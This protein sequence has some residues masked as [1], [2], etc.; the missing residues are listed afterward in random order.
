MQADIP[1]IW[2][3]VPTL[4]NSGAEQKYRAWLALSLHANMP[5]LTKSADLKFAPERFL[6]GV[7]AIIMCALP[8]PVAA[9]PPAPPGV[10]SGLVAL[11][12]R[13]RDYHRAVGALLRRI[14]RTLRARYP[15]AIFRPFCDTLP[16]SERTYAMQAG[17][18]R[19]AR[20]GLLANGLYGT[21]FV[22]GGLL[23]TLPFAEAAGDAHSLLDSKPPHICAH[24]RV[25]ADACPGRSLSTAP[26]GSCMLDVSRCLAWLSIENKDVI[27]IQN[28][29]LFGERIF[30]CDICQ[31]VCPY[32]APQLGGSG[33][34]HHA[35]FDSDH[36]PGAYLPLAE[37]LA[38][39]DDT[40]FA[41]RF[42][43]TALMRAKRR[44]LVRNAIIVTANG[45]HT[46]LMSLISDLQ[47][48]PDPVIAETAR[49]AASLLRQ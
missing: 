6:P 37:I 19:P 13:G 5:C 4:P 39:R 25:C 7:Q 44:G 35:L 28:W 46:S 30:G 12:A 43:G 38:I 36:A 42:S 22:L 27:P 31:D 17:L 26:D 48:D 33:G 9:H 1:A 24:C 20:S 8:L 15:E 23:T 16:L 34:I 45:R 41:Q 14:I 40:A 49:L 21:H 47:R 29:V 2:G 3:A 18:G 11:Y 32:N 10:P